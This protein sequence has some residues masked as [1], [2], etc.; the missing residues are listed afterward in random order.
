MCTD[1]ACVMTVVIRRTHVESCGLCLWFYSQGGKI[2]DARILLQRISDLLAAQG[3]SCSTDASQWR[4][5]AQLPRSSFPGATHGDDDD[6]VRAQH[7][8]QHDDEEDTAGMVGHHRRRQQAAKKA[9]GEPDAAR[10]SVYGSSVGDGSRNSAGIV[11]AAAAIGAQ[12]TGKQ[13]SQ[14]LSIRVSVFLPEPKGKYQIMADIPKT[15][16]LSDAIRFTG[17][18]ESMQEDLQILCA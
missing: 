2:T 5:T 1:P 18:M 8:A 11:N 4:V 6:Q 10:D 16:S 9:R 3:A 15:S 14:V 17:I 13:S 7:A 12:S